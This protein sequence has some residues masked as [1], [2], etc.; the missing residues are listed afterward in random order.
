MT[1]QI[2]TASDGTPSFVVCHPVEIGEYT[3]ISEYTHISQYTTIGK[4]CSIANLCTIGAQK[5]HAEYLTTFPKEFLTGDVGLCL[6]TSIGNDVWVGSNSVIIAGLKVGDGAIIGAGSV[7]TKDVP[8]YTIVAGI[9]AKPLRERFDEKTMKKAKT[10]KFKDIAP[11]S[12]FEYWQM[13][14]VATI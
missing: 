10:V 4:Y 7:V 13:N 5:H 2:L 9:P 12:F 14:P 11:K 6:S 1:Q 8:P 3:Y